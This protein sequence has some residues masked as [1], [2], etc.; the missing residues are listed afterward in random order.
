[1]ESGR[2]IGFAPHEELLE[3]YE[4]YALFC[5]NAVLNGWYLVVFFYF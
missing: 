2:V 4:Q 3:K 5:E 1:M